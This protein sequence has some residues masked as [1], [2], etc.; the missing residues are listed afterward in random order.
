M[1]N[2]FNFMDGL[3]G[4][5]GGVAVTVAAFLLCSHLYRGLVFRLHTLL[6][7]GGKCGWINSYSI[8]QR[9]DCLWGMS[10]ANLLD[11]PLHHWL[12]LPPRS[13]HRGLLSSSSRY[14]F[15]ISFSTRFSLCCDAHFVAKTLHRHTGHIFLNFNRIGWS[16]V[17][18]SL[19]H[20]LMTALQGIGALMLVGY[21]PDE[22]MIVFLP[23]LAGQIVYATL[24]IKVL[25]GAEYYRPPFAPDPN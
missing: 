13:M 6:C 12:S 5:A 17:Q 9:R 2:I 21:G 3:N 24:V 23:F 16:H 14:C 20:F 19:L 11:L 18:V 25:V 8:S 15:S 7:N 22:R 1:T 4:L 10:E